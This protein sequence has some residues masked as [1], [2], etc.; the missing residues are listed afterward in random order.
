MAQPK[1][2]QNSGTDDHLQAIHYVLEDALQV[3]AAIA[4]LKRKGLSKVTSCLISRLLAGAAVELFVGS[5]F[6]LTEP[7]ALRDLLALSRKHSSL[8]VYLAKS[9]ARSTFHPKVYLGSNGKT[10]RLL[11]GSANLTGGG[12]S[13]NHEIS[14]SCGLSSDDEL[15]RDVKKVFSDYRSDL[16]FEQLDEIVLE[17]YRSK[18]KIAQ[19]ARRRVEQEI[20][21]PAE[22]VIDIAKLRTLHD[23]FSSDQGEIAALTK[24]RRDRK[25]AMSVQRKIAKMAAIG[26]LSQRE[27]AEFD[28]MFR[29]LLTSADGRDHLWHSG[30]IHRRGQ[31]ALRQPRKTIALFSLAQKAAKLPP[32]EG[33]ANIR[34]HAKMIPGVGINMVSEIL[35][36]F[37]PTRYAVFHRNTAAALRMLG[38][39]PPKSVTLFS[40]DAYG[41]VCGVVEAVSRRIGGSDL[42]DADA[43]LNWIYHEKVKG[44]RRKTDS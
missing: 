33:Y 4:F 29:N 12:L 37:A 3:S 42:S 38:A 31:A 24:R 15:L 21:H 2:V 40:A 7:D 23:E 1:I 25:Q 43:F 36:T 20:A 30:D 10:A 13:A 19:A 16:R 32:T 6:C 17:R 27:R 28:E 18:F 22:T 39:D 14:L 34:D 5:D 8:K 9:E 35:C 44:G 11:I 41:R 26:S